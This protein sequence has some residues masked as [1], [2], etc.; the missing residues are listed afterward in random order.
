MI[1]TNAHGVQ[2]RKMR[3]CFVFDSLYLRGSSLFIGGAEL[4][5]IFLSHGKA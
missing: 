2:E 1:H 3:G 5:V 4:A